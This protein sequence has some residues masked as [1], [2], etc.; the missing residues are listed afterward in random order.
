MGQADRALWALS[1]PIAST[2]SLRAGK[3]EG[4]VFPP[5][6]FRNDTRFQIRYLI[7]QRV[8]AR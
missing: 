3:Y 4:E 8:I 6:L 1:S 5:L 2:G 7:M